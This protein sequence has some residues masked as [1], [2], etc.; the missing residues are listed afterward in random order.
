MQIVDKYNMMVV[1]ANEML[2]PM[3]LSKGDEKFA[4]ERGGKGGQI[5]DFFVYVALI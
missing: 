2:P 4:I 1:V 5:G 3:S